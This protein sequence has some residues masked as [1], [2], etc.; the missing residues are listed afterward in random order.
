VEQL[1][2]YLAV[3]MP[4]TYSYIKHRYDESNV[5]RFTRNL[6]PLERQRVWG[7]SDFI[8]QTILAEL[9]AT[10]ANSKKYIVWGGHSIWFRELFK[11]FGDRAD[12]VCKQLS[13][14]KIANVGLVSATLRPV[15][16]SET[17]YAITDCMWM[18][19]G[20][21]D[22]YKYTFDRKIF[23]SVPPKKDDFNQYE[24]PARVRGH[25]PST[26]CIAGWS[27]CCMYQFNE[28]ERHGE[29]DEIPS[30]GNQCIIVR[31]AENVCDARKQCQKWRTWQVYNG[32][33][34]VMHDGIKQMQDDLDMDHE[35]QPSY[36]C[37]VTNFGT[38]RNIPAVWR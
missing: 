33:L 31:G 17:P 9:E 11:A 10:F 23:S 35:F 36:P 1:S 16:D 3:Q 26:A 2:E 13:K 29:W 25:P 22:D 6:D 24:V 38:P 7:N 27:C 20:P 34:K 12:P 18:F 32:D 21:S 28:L 30:N 14:V 5:T 15:L 8:K 37:N 4:R 19:L